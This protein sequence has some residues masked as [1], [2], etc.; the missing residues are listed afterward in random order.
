MSAVSARIPKPAETAVPINVIATDRWS[1]RAYDAD[2]TVAAEDLLGVLE[3]ARWAPSCSNDQP[4][5]F[6][7][8]ERASDEEGWQRAFACLDAGNRKWAHAAPVLGVVCAATTFDKDGSPNRWH[9][10]DAGQAAVNLALE[11]A[12]RGLMAH[13]MGGFDVAAV[14][15]QF[16]V[17]ADHEVIAMFALG[18]QLPLER[19]PESMR[20]R[21]TQPRTRKALEQ[22]AFR[23]TWGNGIRIE[24]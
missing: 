13:Q 7:V 10:Y 23:S 24:R 15:E 11:S 21:E 1:G 12:A 8:C 22:I 14:R 6:L 9:A 5:R 3:A 18:Y 4:W 19:V 16:G 20:A 17:P 2:R